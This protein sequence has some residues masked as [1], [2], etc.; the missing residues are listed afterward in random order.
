MNTKSLL[1]FSGLVALTVFTVNCGGGG[2]G[3][4]PPQEFFWF[5]DSDGDGYS[6][7]VSQFGSNRPTNFFRQEELTA[8][9]G[10][11]N[12]NND[13]VHPGGVEIDDDGLDQDCNGFELSGPP[14]V[15]FNGT[16][17][18][19]EDSDYPDLPVRAFRDSNGKVQLVSGSAPRVY[20][21]IGDSLDTVSRDCSAPVIA[22]TESFD[23]SQ[24][25]N[26][27]LIGALYTLDGL[28][29]HALVHNEFIGWWSSDWHAE[30]DFSDVQGL[31]NWRYAAFS[32]GYV[33]M[34]FNAATEKWEG[35]EVGCEIYSR[36]VHPGDECDAVR[37]WVS[38]VNESV[39]ISGEVYDQGI[40]SGDGVDVTISKNNTVL[41]SHTLAEGDTTPIRFDFQEDVIIGDTLYFSVNQRANFLDDSTYFNPKIN[42]GGDPCP[43]DTRG[44]G[45]CLMASLTYAQSTDGGI[46]YHHPQSPPE[47]R[48]ANIPLQYAPDGGIKNIWQPSNIT[49]HPQD[50]FYYAL[51]QRTETSAD[52]M[53]G[54]S[55]VCVMRTDT[56]SDPDSWRAWD[57]TGFNMSFVD[58]YLDPTVDVDAHRCPFVSYDEIGAMTYGLSYNTYLEQFVVIGVDGD[59]PDGNMGF[60]FSTSDDLINWLPKKLLLLTEQRDPMDPTAPF[61]AYPT[62]VD[63]DDPSVNFERPGQAPFFYYSRFNSRG[64]T[65]VDLMRRRVRF[66][67]A[68]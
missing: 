14:E 5:Q 59:W 9:E 32:S 29:I 13:T 44:V 52:G 41:W 10:D 6:N 12:D 31:N 67:L 23:P 50:G 21:F 43:S 39:T 7:G 27:E 61:S 57:G 47:H 38:T 19:C 2:G 24:Y 68:Q 30:R 55:G 49:Q 64:T 25:D 18:R 48:V 28:T 40:G 65:D 34:V 53:F 1:R 54:E 22:S 36:G 16:T 46:S 11:C 56:L 37:A 45:K 35:P 3:K 8:I 4:E 17:D 33:D 66:I 26:Q 15:V 20:R 58:A 51:I 60:Y 62:F 42:I 63:P